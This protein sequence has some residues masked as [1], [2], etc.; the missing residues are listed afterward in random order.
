MWVVR[1]TTSKTFSNVSKTIQIPNK[2][3]RTKYQ[4][5]SEDN[6]SDIQEKEV[7]DQLTASL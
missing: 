2:L 5:T 6:K 1:K 4:I 7:T 3:I